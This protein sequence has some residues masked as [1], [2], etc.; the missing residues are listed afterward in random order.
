MLGSYLLAALPG[1][2]SGSVLYSYLLPKHLHKIDIVQ[3]SD[4]HNPGTAN[5]IKYAG[6]GL[7]M[8]CL[9]LDL[10]KGFFPVWIAAATLD[11]ANPLF[12]LV[13]AAPVCGHAFSPM[14]A[15]R[16]GKAIATTFGVLLGL[17]EYTPLVWYLAAVMVFL[18]CIAAV[19]PHRLRV[20][21][22]FALFG[23]LCLL[24]VPEQG[25]RLAAGAVSALVIYKHLPRPA[26][27]TLQ[28]AFF[29]YARRRHEKMAPLCKAE[30]HGGAPRRDPE[31]TAH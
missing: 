17:V 10:A 16:G 18:T 2:V 27:E 7:G 15:G 4:D 22:A 31:K 26:D 19:H 6:P 29:P 11:S 13:V 1:F 3:N 8:V 5:A 25:Y 24:L 28:V 12:V 14:L 30:R 20:I 21:A 9:T 23:L